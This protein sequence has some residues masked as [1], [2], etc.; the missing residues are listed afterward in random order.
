MAAA[1]AVITAIAASVLISRRIAGPIKVLADASQ[2]IAMGRC[3]ERVNASSRDEL[4]ELGSSFNAMAAALEATEKRRSELIGDVAHEL[5]TPLATLRG[6]LEGLLD[7][8]VHGRRA[9]STRAGRS[10]EPVLRAHGSG[11]YHVSHSA[12]RP[13]EA[14][15]CRADITLGAL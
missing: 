11:P 2:R 13:T 5:R 7:G 4:G 12:A 3:D 1:A 15:G 8:V 9:R 6:Y 10:A 14:A